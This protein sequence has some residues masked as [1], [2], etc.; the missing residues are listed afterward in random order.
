MSL[1]KKKRLLELAGVLNEGMGE[2]GFYQTSLPV[3]DYGNDE[4][5][6]DIAQDDF[7]GMKKDVAK[8]WKQFQRDTKSK[9]KY[10]L[11]DY[12][13]VEFDS[14]NP[15]HANAIFDIEIETDSQTMSAFDEWYG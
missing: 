8:M 2:R 7:D 14:K 11:I 12:D 1:G 4:E 9:G 6:F 5:A 13:F 3:S 15:G 10:K